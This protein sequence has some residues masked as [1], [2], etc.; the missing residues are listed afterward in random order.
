MLLASACSAS[1]TFSWRSGLPPLLRLG[2]LF[3][4]NLPPE[5][6][7][8]S[9]EWHRTRLHPAGVRPSAASLAHSSAFPPPGTPL[10]AGHY[11]I[12]MMSGRCFLTWSVCIWPGPGSSEAI[13]LIA[14]WAS[15]KIVTLSGVVSPLEAVSSALARAA[16]SAS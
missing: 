11:L 9:G 1:C 16:R 10:Y 15:V 7:G 6:C 5:V 4:R 8:R 2:P 14:A 12:S 3:L 13:R